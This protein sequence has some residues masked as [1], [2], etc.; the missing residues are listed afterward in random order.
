ME[1]LGTLL[2]VYF[3]ADESA[4]MGP[5]IGELN[6]GLLSLQ[7]ALQRDPFA[8]CQ[9]AVLGDRVFRRCIHLSGT[10]RLA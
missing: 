4:S 6:H 5:H 9:G 1:P 7:D 3:V 2:P 10:R 8:A